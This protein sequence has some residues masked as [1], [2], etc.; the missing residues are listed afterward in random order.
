MRVDKH[1]PR[2]RTLPMARTASAV[3][4][5]TC[6]AWAASWQRPPLPQNPPPPSGPGSRGT[7]TTGSGAPSTASP[8]QPPATTPRKVPSPV[9]VST[10]APSRAPLPPDAGPQ[11][12][13]A[14]DHNQDSWLS[15]AELEETFA[16]RREEFQLYD[17]DKDGRVTQEE[18]LERFDFVVEVTGWFRPPKEV[19]T[20]RPRLPSSAQELTLQYDASGDGALDAGE[21]GAAL[22]A[23]QRA[24]LSRDGV[25]ALLDRDRSLKLRDEELTEFY[26][27]L[28]QLDSPVA[29]PLQA[30]SIEE[31][32][33][34][35]EPRGSSTTAPVLPPR[36]A[37]PVPFFRRL[38][39]NGNGQIELLDLDA[40]QAPL[41]LNVRTAPVLAAIDRDRNG[42][43]SP[44]ELAQAL[45]D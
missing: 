14:A 18:F 17:P 24:G 2:T 35:L 5:A 30:T 12:F 19:A 40:L 31:L 22:I 42:A 37:G 29:K 39:L 20:G 32:F 36:I 11:Y 8:Q 9:V 23:F 1:F 15:L 6:A 33:G 44:Q 41:I 28:T 4:L 26:G 38:D 13:R 45:G 27:L 34:Q 43:L 7:G 21:I 16:I 3:A 25:M 10:S